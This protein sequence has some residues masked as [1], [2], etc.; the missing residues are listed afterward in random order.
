LA[1][2]VLAAATVPLVACA[3]NFDV[4]NP[5]DASLE[6]STAD[7]WSE[8]GPSLDAPADGAR[9][10][11][12]VDAALTDASLDRDGGS[13]CTAPGACFQEAST[14]GAMCGQVYQRCVRPCDA[15]PACTAPCTSAQQS[16]LGKCA[17][18]CIGC[19]QEAGCVASNSC[20]DAAHP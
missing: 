17:T 11:A 12:T 2:G 5:V 3:L 20:L 13:S 16:C 4:Y 19:T 18:T 15:S 7:A 1:V 9:M 8:G 14:C 10:D 6:G